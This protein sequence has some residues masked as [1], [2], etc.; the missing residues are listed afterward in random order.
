MTVIDVAGR[1]KLHEIAVGDKPEGVT[2]IGQGPLAAVTLYRDDAVVFVDTAAGKVV[3]H[4][5]V[6]DEPYGIVATAD[7][8]RGSTSPTNIPA[9]SA[10]ST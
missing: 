7:G 10:R 4:L 5:T 2:W 9:R 6:A 3:E 1:K 8:S